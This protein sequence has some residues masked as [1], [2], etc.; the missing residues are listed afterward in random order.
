MATK[1]INT[2]ITE[3]K[4][5]NGNVTP[6]NGGHT[7]SNSDYT[8]DSIKVL[9]GMEA[10]RKRPAM[11]IGSTGELGLHHLVYEVV[12]NSVDE[13]LAGFA[14]KI[15]VTIH[16]DN[17]ITVTDDGRGIPVDDMEIDG[18]KVS[19]AQVVM[20]K[21]HAG[22]KFDSSTYKVSGGLH[23]VGVSC[24]NALSEDLEL[25]IWRDGATWQ[26]TYSKGDPTSKLKKTGVAKV[27]T[28]TKVHFL[29][30]RSIFTATEYNYDTLAQRLR[31]LAFLNKG[32]LITLTDERTIDPKTSEA[33]RTEFKYNGGI[34]EFIKHLNR[35]KQVL[36]DK[37]IYMEDD[38]N[39]VH[40]E[41]GL[42]YNDAYSETIF[43]FANNINTV[44]GGTHLSGFRTALT[45]TINYAGQQMGLF[46]DVKE[47]LTGDDVRE[48]LVAVISV[49]L[50]QPQFEGQTKG[51]LNS[52]IAGTVTQFVNERLGAFFE[53]NSTVA[54]KIINKAI[55]ASRAREA[56]RKA[57]DLT[58]RKGALDSGGLPGKLADC[59]ERDPNRCELFLV[60]GESAG[61]TAKQGRDRRFQAI[62]PLKGKILNVEKARIDKALAHEE[63][64]AMITA[65]GMGVGNNDVEIEKL[66]YGKVILMTDADVDGSHIRTLLLTFFFRQMKPLIERGNIYIAQPPLF[67]L[68]KGKSQQYIK[69]EREFIKVMVK[70]AADGL[71]IRYGDGAAKLEGKDLAK[72]M[73]VLDEYLGFFD[74]LDKRVRNEKVTELI[75]KLDLAK[76][77]DFEGDK[78]A[79]PKKIERL[80]KELTKML[81]EEGFKSVESRFD[82]EHNLWEVH[83]VNK[84]GAE[85]VINWELSSSAECRQLIAKFK[86]IEP[87]M[88]PP[89]VVETLTK[90]APASS[91]GDALEDETLATVEDKAEKKAA[92]KTP[93]RKEVEVVKKTN[94]RELRDYVINEG[95]KDFSIQ[96]YKGLGEMTAP[97]LWETTMDPERRT[98]LS[99]RLED[100]AECET[101]FTTLMGEDVEARRKFIEEN[102]LDVKNLDI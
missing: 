77:A 59:S 32:L 73:A 43:S 86:Q 74:K 100:I 52:D 29:P 7:N 14:T 88:E 87:Y 45:R 3:T 84:H 15:E 61:G 63:I 24:V 31:E 20:T 50:S 35:G 67:S 89:F 83:F 62:L 54:K 8:A 101:I 69:D 71:I 44:D 68:K 22:G 95:R 80:E 66:R 39:G 25:E 70:R 23:G 36:H 75:P 79:P 60:E 2:P 96:R 41:I 40:M 4:T 92:A 21:L 30:D 93:K 48:G 97:Q 9:G 28:G 58:R 76:R 102:A 1:E 34:A 47:N 65:L 18:E 72:F 26:Q 16:I 27:K 11:Y 12:D 81:K 94:V 51:K 98:L 49:K 91:N 78:K 37:P 42:Q 33:K 55:D 19:A 99:V 56:A 46:R 82:E 53:Q 57:R 90:A 10:V 6:I 64:R 85:H 38:R 17:S 13:A 5:K